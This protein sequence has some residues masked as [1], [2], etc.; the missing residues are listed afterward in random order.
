MAN[1]FFTWDESAVIREYLRQAHKDGKLTQNLDA[2][3]SKA[4]ET[5]AA[6]PSGDLFT[7]L[8]KLAE[9]LRKKG[10]IKKAQSLEEKILNLKKAEKQAYNSLLDLAHPKD[11]KMADATDNLGDVETLISQHEKIMAVINKTPNGKVAQI[12]DKTG[13][14]LKIAQEDKANEINA[15]VEQ[16]KVEAGKLEEALSS[17]PLDRLTFSHDFLFNLG[18][19]PQI[20]LYAALA[21]L[22]F[23]ALHNFITRFN[24]AYGPGGKIN[25]RKLY[26]KIIG[27][28]YSSPGFEAERE[29]AKTF[30]NYLAPGLGDKFRLTETV[31]AAGNIERHQVNPKEVID[32]VGK[33][34]GGELVKYTAPLPLAVNRLQQRV[35][36]ALNPINSAYRMLLGLKPVTSSEGAGSVLFALNSA[37][38]SLGAFLQNK[39]AQETLKMVKTYFGLGGEINAKVTEVAA[40]LTGLAQKLRQSGVMGADAVVDGKQAQMLAGKFKQALQTLYT[41]ATGG[42]GKAGEGTDQY[43]AQLPKLNALA[44]V[45]LA[46]Q[47]ASQTPTVYS[48]LF[49]QIGGAIPEATSLPK[50]NQAADNLL[51]N[52]GKGASDD[53]KNLTK[54]GQDS[55]LA[56]LTSVP[57][58]PSAPNPLEQALGKTP[59]K[60]PSPPSGMAYAPGSVSSGPKVSEEEKNAVK[61]MQLALRKLAMFVQGHKDLPQTGVAALLSVGKSDTISDMDGLW[62]P[63]TTHALTEAKKILESW[64]QT[65]E[66]KVPADLNTSQMLHKSGVVE[67]AQ[68]NSQI[69]TSFLHRVGGDVTGI[70]GGLTSRPLDWL[71]RPLDFG[72]VEGKGEVALGLKDLSSLAALYDFTSKNNLLEV[73]MVKSPDPSKMDAVGFTVVQWGSL[74]AWL[75]QRAKWLFGQAVAAQHKAA[76]EGAQAYHAM[77][78]KLANEFNLLIN[79]LGLTEPNQVVSSDFVRQFS[80]SQKM[81]GLVEMMRGKGDLGT[82]EGMG[83]GGSREGYGRRSGRGRGGEG[84]GGWDEETAGYSDAQYL[85]PPFGRQ[86][87]FNN[88]YFRRL[89]SEFPIAKRMGVL[90]LEDLQNWTKDNVINMFRSTR[91]GENSNQAIIQALLAKGYV[92]HEKATPQIPP[93]WIYWVGPDGVPWVYSSDGRTSIPATTAYPALAQEAARIQSLNP[94]QSA[95][96]F[97]NYLIGAVNDAKADWLTRARPSRQ[98]VVNLNRFQEM[99]LESLHDK[100]N[101]LM[102]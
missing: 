68:K 73:M 22:D 57:A 79:S 52:L 35:S 26:D 48:D 3:L 55:P 6:Q 15:Y 58:T 61:V 14:I 24:A 47:K 70:S 25:E 56:G 98:Q 1:E 18:N 94:R 20:Q 74:L 93:N 89:T 63:N 83:Y 84:M 50:L 91:G 78:T 21:E 76:A 39:G 7:D 82:P 29:K 62:G 54:L 81:K 10:L 66:E 12:L 43:N 85:Q 59:A 69:L 86:I 67:A 45:V 64:N 28:N 77:A 19:L 96:Q 30:L 97:L 38:N 88:P 5:K 80:A 72:K 36:A 75:Q 65:S 9:G 16:G 60:T 40:N 53:S 102:R 42:K 100:V 46:L 51:R 17:V 41:S 37:A 90:G 101:E 13:E 2:I 27:I 49:Q 87:E 99:W 8:T 32:E 95:V 4:A 92:P 71:P 33:V 11:T 34:L 23:K 44:G 31:N